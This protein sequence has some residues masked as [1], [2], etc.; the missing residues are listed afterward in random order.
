[1]K[2]TIYLDEKLYFDT[3]ICL[4]NINDNFQA[5][6]KKYLLKTK[7]NLVTKHVPKSINNKPKITT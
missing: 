7:C 5:Y 4:F 1:M 2:F 6:Y 3:F